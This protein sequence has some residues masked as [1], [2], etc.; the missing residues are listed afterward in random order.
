MEE[1]L[2]KNEII[3]YLKSTGESDSMT[4]YYVDKYNFYKFNDELILM[5]IKKP[6]IDKVIW[7]DDEREA[8]TLT[9]EYFIRYN[10]KNLT[11]YETIEYD[12]KLTPYLMQARNTDA[13]STC[14][15]TH[16]ALTDY[17]ENLRWAKNKG[18][19]QRFITKEELEEYNN[20]CT[21][22]KQQYIERLKKYFKKYNKNICVSGYWANR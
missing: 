8:P 13:K 10:E 3:E 15:A 9:E 18:Y 16:Y 6:S 21:K 1:I 2:D 7:Y 11:E 20:I 12:E 14:L 17:Y 22:L 19:F 5:F 4:K